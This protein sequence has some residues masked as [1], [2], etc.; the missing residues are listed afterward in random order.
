MTTITVS[1]QA[2]TLVALKDALA[3]ACRFYTSHK[4]SGKVVTLT[5]V[6][7]TADYHQAL[8]AVQDDISIDA[9]ECLGVEVLAIG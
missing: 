4:F 6:C 3:C 8:N 5:Y 7:E 1:L 2:P 9:L